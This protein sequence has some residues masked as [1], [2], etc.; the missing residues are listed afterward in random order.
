MVTDTP[1]SAARWRTE[2]RKALRSLYVS[3]IWMPRAAA[4]REARTPAMV[5]GLGARALSFRDI[6]AAPTTNS[7]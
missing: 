5:A 4:V 6:L 7:Y 1:H 3:H 2:L